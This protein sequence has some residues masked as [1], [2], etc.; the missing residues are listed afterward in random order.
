M[1]QQVEIK[2]RGRGP[3]LRTWIR[4][5]VMFLAL[6]IFGVGMTAYIS[7]D[8]FLDKHSIWLHPAKEFSLLISM[9]GVVSLGY[10]L[11]L[12]ELTFNEYKDALQEIVNP[13]AVRL[14]VR[15]IYKNRSELG[16]A[17]NFEDLFRN[18]KKEIFIGGS[19]LLSIS[20]GSRDLLKQKIMQ[21]IHVRLLVM[22]PDSEVVEIITRQIGGKATFLNEIK[23]SLLLFQKLEEELGDIKSPNK[24]KFQVHTYKTIPSHSFI[25]IDPSDLTGLIIADIGPYLG[26]SHQ[27][28][29]MLLTPKRGG[30]FEQYQELAEI[31]W[32][33]S[34]PVLS[35]SVAGAEERTRA[36]VLASGSGTEVL[37]P[38]TGKWGPSILCK[39]NGRWK[40]I[41]GAQWVSYREEPTLE[42]AITGGRYR[43]RQTFS[44][45]K[46]KA[47]RIVRGDLFV[48]ADDTCH[49]T[50]NGKA[51]SQEFGGADFADPFTVHLGGH[52]VDGENTVEFE[53]LNYAKPN[54][55]APE[56]NPLGL[57][58]RLHVEYPE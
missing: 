25:S 6:V 14:G 8:M 23:T 17:H 26:K 54:A 24:G 51:L 50:V 27:R 55:N 43:F 33:E 47:E 5:R 48:R 3:A 2:P 57:I 10:E 32:H 56:D 53:V 52:L 37:D 40:A 35:S 22:D 34:R 21:G 28:P 45:P 15:G 31:M 30:L 44:L 7:A 39:M 42:S 29:S 41:K 58:Y 4:D 20:T 16:H 38:E 36:L 49:L 11:F 46:G 1:T 13:D 19:S 18:V 12:R 9:I